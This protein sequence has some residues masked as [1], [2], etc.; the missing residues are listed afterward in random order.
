MVIRLIVLILLAVIPLR[1]MV[2]VVGRIRF[3]RQH[4][5]AVFFVTHDADNTACGPVCVQSPVSAAASCGDCH[6][7]K[8]FGH[9]LR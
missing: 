2:F 1:L 5:A 8:D 7:S 4:I 6:L 9:F 3:S